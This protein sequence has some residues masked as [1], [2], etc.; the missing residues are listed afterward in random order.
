[1][2][3]ISVKD[4]LPTTPAFVIDENKIISNLTELVNLKKTIRVPRFIFN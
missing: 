2:E 4:N 1:M 3:C